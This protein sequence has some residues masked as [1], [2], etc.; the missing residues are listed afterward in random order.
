[1]VGVGGD[2]VQMVNELGVG[3]VTSVRPS[4]K[5]AAPILVLYSRLLKLIA[6]R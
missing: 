4:V 3:V 6:E 2:P 1:M 5:A